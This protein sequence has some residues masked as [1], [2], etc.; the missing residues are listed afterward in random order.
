MT[1]E[2]L[3][4]GLA[5][6]TFGLARLSEPERTFQAIVRPD[7]SVLDISSDFPTSSTLYRDWDR[8]FDRLVALNE[9]GVPLPEPYSHFGVLPPT[10]HPQ[11][12]GAGSN[13]LQHAAEM[14]THTGEYEKLRAEGESNESFFGRN[15]EFMKT[16]RA[17]G[18]PFIFM[19]THGAVVGATD[20]IVLPPIGV[21]HDW[22]G[23]LG[24]VLT[25][26][27]PRFMDPEE[28]MSHIAGFTMINDMHTLD[29]FTR[30][31][32]RWSHDWIIKQ[33]PGSKIAG[34]FVVPRQFADALGDIRIE[35]RVNGDVKQDWP[36]SD[37]I[38]SPGEIVAYASERMK[39]LA[40]D[41]VMTGS[42]PGNGG[43]HG[44]YLSPGDEVTLH[45]TGLGYQR[46]SVVA[47]P[48]PVGRTPFY[49]LPPQD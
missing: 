20:D 17:T 31:D 44:Q 35:L 8:T 21:K 3:T 12:L 9:T 25:G 49:G 48:L 24:L 22:E 46:N 32:I 16:R 1:D 37:M 38:F 13:Y 29:Y 47:E 10:E 42:P 5:T 34:P 19:V 18:I 40:G 14:Y 23:E 15:M 7:G 27:S 4:T 41:L 33:Q 11:V 36:T 6:G 2:N 39:I 45:L 26:D 43:V 28:A 30:S